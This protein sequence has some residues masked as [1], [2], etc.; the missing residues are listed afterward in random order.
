M[1]APHSVTPEL[2]YKSFL[3]LRGVLAAVIAAAPAFSKFV[4]EPVS[5]Y[6]FPPLGDMA[7]VARLAVA[8][9]A[10]G[11]TYAVC[12][13]QV[14]EAK[15][16]RS[17]F[18]ALAVAVVALFGYLYFH[19]EFVRQLYIPTLSR[20]VSVCI[21]SERTEM[22]KKTF[23]AASDEELLRSRGFD[24]EQLRWLWTPTSLRIARLALF[25]T[26]S[27]CAWALVAMCSLGV[28]RNARLRHQESRK[29]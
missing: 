10:F 27:V 25:F 3:S 20:S 26:Y 24:D 4:E 12:V 29:L 1:P 9:F 16:N 18:S 2:F 13:W 7:G 19:E 6:L 8:V 23:G 22:A 17:L 21:G 11:V 28:L 15:I 14:A 5:A